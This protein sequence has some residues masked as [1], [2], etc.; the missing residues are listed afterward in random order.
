MK[1]RERKPKPKFWVP[2]VAFD[3]MFVDSLEPTGVGSKCTTTCKTKY[4]KTRCLTT[5]DALTKE[6]INEKLF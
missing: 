3:K 2:A 6:N 5:C 1:A 4:K